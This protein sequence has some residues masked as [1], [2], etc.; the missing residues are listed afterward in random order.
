MAARMKSGDEIRCVREGRVDECAPRGIRLECVIPAEGC[1]WF[2][3]AP[4]CVLVIEFTTR[5]FVSWAVTRRGHLRFKMYV[6]YFGFPFFRGIILPRF[7][8][9]PIPRFPAFPLRLFPTSSTYMF[10]SHLGEIQVEKLLLTTHTIIL[11]GVMADGIE[12][13]IEK[14]SDI[15]LN[16]FKIVMEN[17]NSPN[18]PNEA[19]PEVNP[20]IP[21]P[22]HVD[23]A[24]DP[25]EMVDIPDDEELL[26]EDDDMNENF[27]D[28]DI[29]DE[30]VEI[31]VDDDA[32]LI[33]PYEVEGDQTLPPR[34][35]S[36]DSKPPNAESSDSKSEDEEIEVAPEVD[37]APEV[38]VAPEV[39]VVPEA[40]VGTS[41]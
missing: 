38:E 39:D 24:Y 12:T 26:E 17:P 4:E 1:V 28:E 7:P 23:D 33:F 32:E 2:R 40:T 37:V 41:T 10:H 19:I 13:V 15:H 9:F 6:D 20:V 34:D 11:Q 36:S 5:V 30:D 21:E 14:G 8:S 27:N 31:E 18:E 25:N 22:N 29:E 3:L 16:V 35:E